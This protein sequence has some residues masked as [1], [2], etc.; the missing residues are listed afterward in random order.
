MLIFAALLFLML[1]IRYTALKIS[2]RKYLF[3]ASCF[4]SPAAMA[5]ALYPATATRQGDR[6][7]ASLVDSCEFRTTDKRK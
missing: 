1:N 5:S 2:V 6:V 3:P 7:A 4:Y